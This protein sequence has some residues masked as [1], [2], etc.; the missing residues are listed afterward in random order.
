MQRIIFFSPLSIKKFPPYEYD[1]C[2]A[3]DMLEETSPSEAV[4][5]KDVI[6]QAIEKEKLPL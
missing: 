1:K 2:D 5:Y 6:L 4:R 3:N